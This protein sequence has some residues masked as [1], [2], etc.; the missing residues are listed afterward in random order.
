M[1]KYTDVDS[2]IK[3]FPKDV[4]SRLKTLRTIIKKAAPKAEEAFSYGIAGYK[5]YGK[6]LVYFGGF[7]KHVSLYAL[8]SGTKAFQKDVSA[9]KTSKGTVQFPH[10]RPLP[11]S[12]IR[13][14]VAYR[15]RENSEKAK[16]PKSRA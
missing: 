16:V 1:K 7:E 5:L 14:I 6:P 12:L 2:Y 13:K 4:Q 3:D 15:V 9:Y 8:P 10:R 11:I